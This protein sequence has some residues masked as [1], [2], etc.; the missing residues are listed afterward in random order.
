MAPLSE[1]ILTSSSSSATASGSTTLHDFTTSLQL[2]TLK[3]SSPG[4][5]ST[6][7]IQ[8]Q[9]GQGGICAT[10]MEGKPLMNVWAWQKEQLHQKIPLP[11][12]LTC[13][14]ISPTST[15]CA[16]GTQTG[17]I[18]LWELSSGLLF[19]SFDAHYRRINI[20]KFTSDGLGLISGSD[21]SGVSVW[22]VASL[23][24]NDLQKEIPTAL[25]NLS[26]HTLPITD[27]QIGLGSF[28]NECRVLTSSVDH[29]V[30]LWQLT[31]PA[32]LLSTYHL[33]AP[34][35]SLAFDPMERAFWASAGK[36]VFAVRLFERRSGEEGGEDEEAV[37]VGKGKG[38]VKARG[39]G[40]VGEVIRIERTTGGEAAVVLNDTITTLSLSLSTSHLL[41]GTST[42]QIHIHSL[43]SLQHLRTLSPAAHK[44]CPITH[45]STLLRPSDLHGHVSL[46]S[47]GSGDAG[48]EK[49]AIKTVGTL[50]RMR[51]GRREREKHEV[52][53]MMGE[54]DDIFSLLPLTAP[55]ALTSTNSSSS[56]TT[57]T[58]APSSSTPSSTADATSSAT[59]ISS[60]EGE[61]ARLK[62][63]LA[64]A[65]ALNDKMWEGVVAGSLG[66]STKV[67]GAAG[68]NATASTAPVKGSTTE[69]G[70]GGGK[71]RR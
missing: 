2:S 52:G 6:A 5:N 49:W 29:T 53:W 3:P 69:G 63:D 50:E 17:H 47:V 71:R 37:V 24:S 59:Q 51:V 15:Y 16:G 4:P 48:D 40:G 61:V 42:G 36:E 31:S 11:E 43:P 23:V 20:L 18:Y 68:T 35:T 10:V 54:V 7:Y 56:H 60:L 8:T 70:G 65:K 30:K 26:D 19:N 66:T 22:S 34:P 64:K 13:F 44:S 28:P 57:S 67:A 45:I 1:V 41:L 46:G 38:K 25:C 62:A 33:P 58:V 55:F 9:Y 14:T 32:T 39:G 12:K 27:I 21:D